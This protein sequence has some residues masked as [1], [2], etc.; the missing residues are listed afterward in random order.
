[1]QAWVAVEGLEPGLSARIEAA[2]T[3]KPVRLAKIETVYEDPVA[4]PAAPR[5]LDDLA[6]LQPDDLF[7]RWHERR[8]GSA[9]DAGLRELWWAETSAPAMT[10]GDG[11]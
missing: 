6:R 9:P 8:Y 10:A 3:D 5:S 1:M 4:D 7:V 2:L 11:S